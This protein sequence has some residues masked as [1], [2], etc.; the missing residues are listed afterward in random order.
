MFV[1]KW[2]YSFFTPLSKDSILSEGEMH[3]SY[4]PEMDSID[5]TK[6]DDILH[7]ISRYHILG[8]AE[9][10]YI[11]SLPIIKKVEFSRNYRYNT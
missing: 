10:D 7:K 8:D 11:K 1:I 9:Y 4:K 5:H 3:G 2:I 6:F